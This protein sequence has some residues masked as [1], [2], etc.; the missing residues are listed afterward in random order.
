[1]FQI[2]ILRNTHF[3]T[4]VSYV[5]NQDMFLLIGT[6]FHFFFF[7]YVLLF[8][9]VHENILLIFVGWSGLSLQDKFTLIFEE[10][11][12]KQKLYERNRVN[13]EVYCFSSLVC[14]RTFSIVT[15][16]KHLQCFETSLLSSSGENTE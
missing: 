14:T 16:Y 9:V 13:I 7:N 10:V 1:M 3:M 11:E 8:P 15:K 4:C 6:G 12:Y 2:I 5:L